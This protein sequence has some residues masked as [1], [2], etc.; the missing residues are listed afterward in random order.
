MCAKMYQ[1]CAR[2]KKV[3]SK[4]II[5][6]VFLPHMVLSSDEPVEFSNNGNINITN[7]TE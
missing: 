6:A 3:I 4:I 2:F 1:K 7:V 5:G